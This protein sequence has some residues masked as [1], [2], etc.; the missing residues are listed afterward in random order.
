MWSF[1][2]L[3]KLALV[4][5][6]SSQRWHQIRQLDL[7]MDLQEHVE[8]IIGDATEAHGLGVNGHHEVQRL[9]PLAKFRWML[10][11]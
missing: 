2:A 8:M 9:P 3:L 1:I 7:T 6:A 11:Q 4:C 10:R 5:V